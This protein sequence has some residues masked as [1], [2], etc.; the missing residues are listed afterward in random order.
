[1]SSILLVEDDLNARAGLVEILA[2]EGY[3]VESAGDAEAALK[4]LKSGHVDLLLSDFRLP[5]LSGIELHRKVKEV[6]PQVQTIIMSAYCIPERVVEAQELGVFSWLT[7]P[8]QV[9]ALLS[10]IKKAL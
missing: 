1:M 4:K 8:L 5:D 9:D 10:T 2:D 3:S 6:N 7:K